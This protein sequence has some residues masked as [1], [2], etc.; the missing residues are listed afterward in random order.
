[1][2]ITKQQLIVYQK[3]AGDD[4]GLARVGTPQEKALYAPS[5]WSQI[6]DLIQM[7][8]V[9]NKFGSTEYKARVFTNYSHACEGSEA[10]RLLFEIVGIEKNNV[11]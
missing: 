1:M 7:L 10:E 4:D 5:E 8:T 6:R 9:A 3:Y 2:T 11:P